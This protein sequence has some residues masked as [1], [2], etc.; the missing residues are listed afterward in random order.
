MADNDADPHDT[1]TLEQLEG[2]ACTYRVAN[3]RAHRAEGADREGRHA[4][5]NGVRASAVRQ[6]ALECGSDIGAVCGLIIFWSLVRIQHGLPEIQL[7][8]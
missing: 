1:R 2:P 6:V 4:A 5:R 3:G 8:Q 7:N